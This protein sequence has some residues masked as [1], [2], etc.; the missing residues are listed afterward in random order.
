VFM[1]ARWYDSSLGRW[2]Q[3]DS[4]V[5]GGAQGLDRYGFVN[6]NPVR[7]SDPSGH[8]CFEPGEERGQSHVNICPKQS[9]S[10]VPLTHAGQDGHK[11]GGDQVME[12]YLLMKRDTAGWWYADGD[13]TLEDFIGILLMAEG[14][15][16]GP[17]TE[18]FLTNDITAGAQSLYVGGDNDAYCPSMPCGAN[19]VF[20]YL[21]A[22]SGSTWKLLDTFVLGKTSISKFAATYR[23]EDPETGAIESYSDYMTRAAGYG[24]RMLNP[25]SLARQRETALSKYG[26][27]PD[28]TVKALEVTGLEPFTFYAEGPGGIYYF[29]DWLD[30]NDPEAIWYSSSAT[31]PK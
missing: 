15:G 1:N 27:F 11:Y 31:V 20:N 2:A 4:L 9:S 26:N 10:D 17:Y 3:A 29:T 23:R 12:L 14:G 6:N 18:Q 16:N 8:Y 25:S 21:A 19:G 24:N 7:Y 30:P 28:R 5:P 13:F 22:T